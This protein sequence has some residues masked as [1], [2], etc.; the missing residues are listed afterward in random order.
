[1]FKAMRWVVAGLA[2]QLMIGQTLAQ[3]G[4]GRGGASGLLNAALAQQKS[5]QDELKLSEE[6]IEKLKQVT[7]KMRESFGGGAAGVDREELRKK[8][9]EARQVAEKDISGILS[10]EQTKRLKE[11]TLQQ[12]G[13]VVL[14]RPELAKEIGLTDD[15]VAK[16]N[17]INSAAGAEARARFQAGIGGSDR[18]EARKKSEAAQKETSDKVLALLKDDQKKAW[19]KLVGEPF[20]GD[21]Q[22]FGG[23]RPRNKTAQ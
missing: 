17:E 2:L 19:E 5:V 6:Q 18:E 14:A 7:T 21:I 22:P 12:F 3:P 13:P 16:I 23:N 10:A 4:G 8:F 20:K 11:I 9:E 1:M 15:Q